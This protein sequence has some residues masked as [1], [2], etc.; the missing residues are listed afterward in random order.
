[1]QS[2]SKTLLLTDGTIVLITAN[3]VEDLKLKYAPV[4]NGVSKWFL[5]IGLSL[6]ILKTN[7]MK[8]FHFQ[9]DSLL[10]HFYTDKQFKK[11]QI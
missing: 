9:D 3:N 10:L 5:V 8:F 2:Y 6:N 1:M 7:V 4:L 11:Q